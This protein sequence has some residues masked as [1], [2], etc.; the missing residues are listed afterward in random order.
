MTH[1]YKALAGE[2]ITETAATMSE[3]A[4]DR[5]EL[6]TA[7]FNGITLKASPGTRPDSIVRGFHRKMDRLAYKHRN[8]QEGV[9]EAKEEERY[10]KA[11]QVSMDELMHRFSWVDL[12]D[13]GHLIDWLVALCCTGGEKGIRYDRQ[14]VIT[15]LESAGYVENDCSGDAFNVE[16]RENFARY[17]V[18]QALDGLKNSCG[19]HPMFME[20]AKQWRD[21]FEV[22]SVA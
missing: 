12:A 16:D 17:L 13:L 14:R 4:K 11:R 20:F 2:C 5:G 7:R 19:I 10:L 22:E 21:K 9:A 6:I 3:M 18:G 15:A 1:E 8:S